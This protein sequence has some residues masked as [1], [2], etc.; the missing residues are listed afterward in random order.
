MKLNINQVNLLMNDDHEQSSL[1]EQPMQQLRIL[2]RVDWPVN[3]IIG[4]PDTCDVIDIGF[5]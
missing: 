3:M 2:P 5:N 1:A 4:V